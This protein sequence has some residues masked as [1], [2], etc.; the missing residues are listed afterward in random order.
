MTAR[1]KR[2][3]AGAAAGLAAVVVLII[4]FANL[5]DRHVFPSFLQKPVDAFN[6][7][8]GGLVYSQGSGQTLKNLSVHFIDVGQGDS[9][10]IYCDGEEMLIDGGPV[11]SDGKS[12]RYLSSLGVKTLKYMIATHPDEDHIGGLPEV[13]DSFG[14]S[15]LLLSGATANT[16]AFETFL[17]SVKTRK[18]GAVKVAPGQQYTLGGGSFTVLAPN[19]TYEDT[20]DMSVVIRFCYKN[21]SFL[22][23][24]DASKASEAD[25]LKNGLT[26]RSDVLKAGHH[27][28]GSAT[29]DAFLKAVAPKVA[30]ISVGKNNVYG[31]PAQKTIDKLQKAGVKILRTDDSGTIVMESD[32]TS[33][34]YR[35]E[36]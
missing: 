26:L 35:T 15:K 34:T 32:G 21:R 31:L 17:K 29:S 18:V 24:G 5:C 30:V 2:R 20:N 7:A 6:S 25:M 28:S 36:R 3:K 1:P 22:F 9:I 8:T 33:L 19:R 4:L 12:Q 14:V 16:R 13:V 27:G 23:T 11:D 10:F